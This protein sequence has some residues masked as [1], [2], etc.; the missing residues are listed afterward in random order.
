M[1]PVHSRIWHPAP[2]DAAPRPAVFLDRDGVLTE[3]TGYLSD[4]ESVRLLPEAAATVAEIRLLGIPIVL[5]T[6]QSGIGRGYFG[7]DA[8][9]KVSARIRQ[10]LADAGTEIDAEWA[11]GYYPGEIFPDSGAGRF[12]KPNP[13]MI[14]EAARRLSLDLASSWLAGD[15]PS[16]IEAA[17]N[18]GLRAA[19]H[20]ESG[21][22]AATRHEV[23]ELS[24]ANRSR[25]AIRFAPSIAGLLPL[26]TDSAC[27][28]TGRR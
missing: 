21:C 18:A 2:T 4:P 10:K 28:Y 9:E 26:L 8:Y 25:C 20:V 7:W 3:D 1:Q 22:G 13:G 19:V 27:L 6:N 11:C 24:R 5:V 14:L 23:I 12:R 16:D 15:K 17:L